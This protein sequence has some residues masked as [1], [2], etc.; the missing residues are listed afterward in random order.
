MALRWL[1]ALLLLCSAGE[2]LRLRLPISSRGQGRQRGIGC[3]R[4]VMCTAEDWRD[5]RARLVAMEQLERQRADEQ[6]QPDDLDAAAP[7][8]QS[9]GRIDAA[10]VY[11]TPLIEQGSVILGGTQQEFGFALRQQYFHKSVM[12]LLQHDSSF[13][14]GIIL[15]RPSAMELD[16]WRVWFGGDVAEGGFFHGGTPNAGAESGRREI[17]CLHSL[18]SAAAVRLSMPVIR[19]VGYTTLEGANAL[20]AEGGP[21]LSGFR[22]TALLSQ[23]GLHCR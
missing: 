22:S 9:E 20:I 6:P 23:P 19:G 2:A 12:L 16:G 15:N 8:Q 4:G 5:V 14:R 10:K 1:G 18:E 17:V 3:A 13:T 7:Q 21:C 11:E